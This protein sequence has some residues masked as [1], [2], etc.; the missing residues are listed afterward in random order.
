MGQ[1]GSSFATAKISAVEPLTSTIKLVT[2][3][4]TKG[5]VAF[6]AG[7]FIGVYDSRK[8]KGINESNIIF[9]GTFS[10]A[11]PPKD[12]PFISFAVGEDHNPRNLRNFLFFSA[13]VGDAIKLDRHGSGTVALTPS[14]VM[15][16]VGGP[17]GLVLIGGGSAVMGLVSIVEELLQD[18][19][20]RQIPTIE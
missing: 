5:S 11:S 6:Q 19:R 9:P 16:P 12:L 2:L 17:G 14:M 10:I 1:P 18:K 8:Q 13:K 7:Q 15:T 20:G 4:I 3:K